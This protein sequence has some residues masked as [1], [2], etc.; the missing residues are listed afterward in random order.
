MVMTGK[1][2]LLAA[3]VLAMAACGNPT[4]LGATSDTFQAV[5]TVFAFS[6][7]PLSAPSAINTSQ[8]QAV[9]TDGSSNYDVAF[10]IRDGQA[11]ALAP[12]ALGG[13]GAAAIQKVNT[14]FESLLEAPTSGYSDTASIAVQPGD[15]LVVQAQ[16]PECSGGFGFAPFVYSKLKILEINASDTTTAGDPAL[17]PRSFRVQM[18]VDP[19]CNFRSFAPGLPKN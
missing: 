10:D 8:G 11:L 19:N 12:L 2:L 14:S 18:V 15:V 5:L 9:L 3:G 7:T 4:G 13:F 17:P 6:G 1:S 16:P